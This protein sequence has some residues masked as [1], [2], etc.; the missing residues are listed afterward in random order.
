M[1]ME[2]LTHLIVNFSHLIMELEKDIES[3]DL[4]PVM[5]TKDKCVIVDARIILQ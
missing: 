5:C 1:N 3:V 4:N 2:V